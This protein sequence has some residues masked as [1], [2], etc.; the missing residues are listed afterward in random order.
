MKYCTN[1]GEKTAEKKICDKCGFRFDSTH[2]F[3]KWCGAEIGE[4]KKRCSNCGEKNK[5]SFILATIIKYTISLI[6]IIASLGNFGES[7]VTATSLLLFGILLL[8]VTNN[9]F[10]QLT[11]KNGKTHKVLSIARRVLLVVLLV[12]AIA[13]VPSS[14]TNSTPSNSTSDT[15]VENTDKESVVHSGSE[16]IV[17]AKKYVANNSGYLE[18]QIADECN[19]K[20]FYHPTYA[21]YDDFAH[22]SSWSV[23]V[24]GNISGY[25]DDYATDFKQYKFEVILS[26]SEDGSVSLTS[27]KKYW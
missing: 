17:A 20:N 11:C 25:T 27:I 19:F 7:A 15:E 2:N 13:T 9:L 26:V 6:L 8:P 22:I 4:N 10:K 18:Q 3:C 23:H 12:V 24:K 5:K 21:T 1:C 14:E 16:A